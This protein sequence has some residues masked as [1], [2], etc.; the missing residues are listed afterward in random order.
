MAIDRD[1]GDERRARIERIMDEF[2]EAERRSLLKRG[3]ESWN[4]TG[5]AQQDKSVARP[6]SPV[7]K[8]N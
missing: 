4:R 8:F 3:I 6:G 1:D 5:R 2:R 7:D